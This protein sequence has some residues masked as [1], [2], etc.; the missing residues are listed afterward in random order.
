MTEGAR[1]HAREVGRRGGRATSWLAWS[2]AALSVGVLLASF[3]VYLLARSAPVPASWDASLG[4]G[5]QLGSALLLAFPIVGAL[6]AS[7]HPHNPIG[8]IF[9]ADGL[10]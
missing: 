7:R 6:I 1:Q 3:P 2:L 10:L 5:S 8:W 4:I 9:L